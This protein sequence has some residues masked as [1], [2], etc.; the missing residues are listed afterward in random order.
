MKRALVSVSDKK[1]LVPFV[2]KLAKYGFEIISTGGTKRVLEEAGIETVSV[3]SVTGFPEILD[4]RVKTLNPF[5]HGGLLGRRDLPEH[6]ATMEKLHIKPIDLVCV[7]LYPFKETIEKPDV[8]LETA[9]EN[10]DIGGPSMLRSAAKNFHDVTVVVD[11]ADYASIIKEIDEQGE[12]SLETRAKL[13]AKVFRHTA[14]YDTL[15]ATYLSEQVGVEAPE[16]LTL[17]YELEDTMRYGENS[18]QKAWFYHDVLPKEYSIAN[19]D[20]LHG[21]KL[22][23]NNIKDADAA[24]RIAREFSEPTVVALKHMNPCG[25]GRADKLEQA[26]DLAYKADPISIFGGVIVLN[27]KVDLNTAEK[28]HKLFLEIIIAPAFDDDAYEVLA[29]KKNLRLLTLNFAKKDELMKKELVSVMGGVLVQEQ[30]VLQE[31]PQKWE[32]V[33]QTAPTQ[34]QLQTLLFAWKAVKH[35]KSNAIV[36]ADQNRTLG[37]GAGQPNRIDSTKIAVKHAHGFI[38]DETVMASDAFFPMDDCVQYA[39][40]HGIK[41]I[42][43]PGGSIRD[44]D[45]IAMA[46]KYGISMVTTGIRHFRH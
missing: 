7:N 41:A 42:V 27:R 12:T 10:I 13:S 4:G 2:S 8:D 43:Q 26:W 35:T 46:D 9:I 20:Q 3:E 19:A 32:V 44:K 29:K 37:I 25:I 36:I 28:M 31:D 14:A 11:T 30:D 24:I 5:I 1:N 6:V 18:H 40:E 45:S 39:A 23:Y 21:K 16:K 38:N 34:T 33:T 22:S 17:T 15:I